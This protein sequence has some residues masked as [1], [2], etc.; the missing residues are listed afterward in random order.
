MNLERIT[1]IIQPAPRECYVALEGG[2]RLKV[3]RGYERV[4]DRLMFDV[5]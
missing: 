1:E 2:V 4:I 5:E 3:T